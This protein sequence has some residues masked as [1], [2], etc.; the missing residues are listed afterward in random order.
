MKIAVRGGHNFLATGSSAL[1]DETTEDRRVKDS[2]IK[3]L[4]ELG[5]DV[6][7]VT[8]GNMDS[9]SDLAYGVNKANNWG[10][11]LFIS[12]HFNKAYNSYNGAIGTETWVYSKRDN[13]KQ[14]EEI[15]LRIVNAIAGLGFK[16]R[17]VKERI[18]LYE[19]K[20]TKMASIIVEVCFVEATEDVALYRK[21]GPDAIGK[22]IAEAIS[23]R[24]IEVSKFPLP[25][26]MKSDAM[27]YDGEVKIFNKGDLLTADAE[28]QWAY[29]IELDGKR[30]WVEKA[31]VKLLG[32]SDERYRRFRLQVTEYP[33]RVWSKEI[34]PFYKG[35]LITAQWEMSGYY[36][37]DIDGARAYI[38]KNATMN[39]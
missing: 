37:L 27:S 18:D 13:I 26:K 36:A 15:A 4:R 31:N 6:L 29:A 12:I 38:R 7:D 24:K 2:V 35:E 19:L 11:E 23:N 30:C 16:N 5:N 39:R 33:C 14:D 22:A 9:D 17:G 34:K 1:I 28:N 3:Y 10:A 32:E 20:A 21:L 8:P 25:L